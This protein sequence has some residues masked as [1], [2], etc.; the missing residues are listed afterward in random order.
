MYNYELFECF[1]VGIGGF[2]DDVLYVFC[3]DLFEN[4]GKVFVV[5]GNF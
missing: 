5:I 2:E 4:G 3:V 1:V